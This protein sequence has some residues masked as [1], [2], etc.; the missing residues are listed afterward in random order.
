MHKPGPYLATATTILAIAALYTPQPLLP[1][2]ARFFDVTRPTAG[3][4]VT[5]TLLPLGFAPIVYGIL[6]ERFSPKLMIQVS[7]FL[8]SVT[9]AGIAMSSSFPLVV[10]LRAV[11]GFLIPATLTALMT[12]TSAQATK[13]SVGRVMALYVTSTILG[14]FLGRFG[15]GIIA[16]WFGWRASFW[17]MALALLINALFLFAFPSSPK[18]EQKQAL[19]LKLAWNIVMKR[20][21]LPIFSAIFCLFFV[22]QALLNFLPFRL[23]EFSQANTELRAAF[24]Y[25]GYLAG[26]IASLTSTRTALRLGGEPRALVIGLMLYLISLFLFLFPMEIWLYMIMFLFCGSMFFVHSLAP[27][28]LNARERE[29]KGVVNGLYIAFYYLGGTLG[30]YLPGFIYRDFGWEVFVLCL[31]GVLGL[32]VLLAWK[33]GQH[34]RPLP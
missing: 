19:T 15:S 7:V 16:A 18:P 23:E 34:L 17:V 4:L 29:H 14:G 28:V 33:A 12:T 27:G 2:L 3:L 25:F 11:Q 8:L 30:S 24:L 6:L 22:F 21:F 13:Q 9:E 20:G 26:L 5:V 32:A 1:T 10:L 31:S